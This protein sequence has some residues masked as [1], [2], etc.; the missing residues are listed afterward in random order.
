MFRKNFTLEQIINKLREAEILNYHHIEEEKTQ[1]HLP[2]QTGGLFSRNDRTPSLQSSVC[3]RLRKRSLVLTWC[4][5]G[6]HSK[7]P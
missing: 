2:F 1:G 4:V 7:E 6:D 3:D 5:V